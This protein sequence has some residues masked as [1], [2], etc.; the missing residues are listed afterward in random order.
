MSFIKYVC[1]QSVYILCFLIFFLLKFDFGRDSRRNK[2][3]Q[4]FL[5]ILLKKHQNHVIL[6]AKKN[7]KNNHKF[8]MGLINNFDSVW[9][10]DKFSHT[11]LIFVLLVSDHSMFLLTRV[12]MAP[13]L[14]TT[15]SICYTTR[16][17]S[18]FLLSKIH[19]E[20]E[21]YCE[22]SLTAWRGVGGT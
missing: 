16:H 13:L 8:L 2:I 21:W 18:L 4:N 6:I 19:K 11:H 3:L 17:D 12:H 1:V 15:C 10:R 5:Q 14:L 9:I 7:D 20:F 22:S